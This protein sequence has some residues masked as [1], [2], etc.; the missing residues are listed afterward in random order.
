[1]SKS[2]TELDVDLLRQ[3]VSFNSE[4]G[5]MTWKPRLADWFEHDQ[6]REFFNKN[7]AGTAAFN[8]LKGNGYI[9]GKCQGK[10][11]LAHR[12]IWA[13]HY[14]SWPKGQIDHINRI[15]TDNRI[16]NL[17]DVSASENNRNMPMSIRN[18]SGAVG[19][20]FEKNRYRARIYVSGKL[21]DL[22]GYKTFDE[23]YFARKNA[24]KEH[25]Y[26]PNHGNHRMAP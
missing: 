5:Q 6:M 10:P 12:V 13:L 26:H 3:F 17:R 24:E 16:V 11:L 1:M 18:S 15:K 25:G 21:L 7:V 23:A 2:M 20:S 22:G 8:N 4:T 9:G 14:G 19:V